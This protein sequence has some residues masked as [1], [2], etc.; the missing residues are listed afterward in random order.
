MGVIERQRGVLLDHQHADLLG[1]VKTD[2]SIS[3]FLDPQLGSLWNLKLGQ[4]AILPRIEGFH[5]EVFGWQRQWA[6]IEFLRGVDNNFRAL[7]G[8][9]AGVTNRRDRGY[10]RQ[11]QRR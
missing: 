4:L 11:R 1:L 3:C 10:R 8:I 6:W 7:R 2:C 5:H 9:S